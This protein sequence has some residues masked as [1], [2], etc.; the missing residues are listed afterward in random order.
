[1]PIVELIVN[2]S[3]NFQIRLTLDNS[4]TF[5]L[6]LLAIQIQKMLVK[7]VGSTVPPF[8]I[9]DCRLDQQLIPY[10]LDPRLVVDLQFMDDIQALNLWK[11]LPREYE[12][13][14]F[15]MQ[16]ITDDEPLP[17]KKGTFQNLLK[18]LVGSF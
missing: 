17:K 5:P 6:K 18:K 10:E 12:A 3:A 8:I 2:L 1:M 7:I 13:V 15:T 9:T 4:F 16:K 14:K 11:D